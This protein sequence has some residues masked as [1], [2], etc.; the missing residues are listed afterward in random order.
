MFKS[1]DFKEKSGSGNGVSKIINPGT[2]YCRII[3]V[4][5]DAPAYNKDAYHIVLKVEGI[6][7]GDDFEGLA[8]DK[9]NPSLGNY[10]GQIGN[11]KSG[12]WPFSTYTYEGKVIQR[13]TQMYNWINNVAKQMGV[14]AKMNEKGVEA[15]TIEEYIQEVRKY[16]IDPELWGYFTI[17]GKE[18]FNEGYSNPN[19]RLFFPKAQPRKNLYPFSALE[20]DDRKPLNLINFSEADHIVRAKVEESAESKEDAAPIDSFEPKATSMSD[21]LADD[22]PTP[23]EKN[24]DLELPF[25]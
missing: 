8:V 5:L 3:D 18:Y 12:D 6:D 23:G 11:V 4:T 19:Y 7:R 20:D 10:R 24:D 1:S 21:S 17:A 16:L 13:D 9:N 22:F 2:H 14:L 15:D 25:G